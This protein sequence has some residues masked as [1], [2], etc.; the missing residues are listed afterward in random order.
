MTTLGS[1]EDL[2]GV[3][4]TGR[5]GGE[6]PHHGVLVQIVEQIGGAVG[7]RE[8]LHAGPVVQQGMGQVG[9]IV[10]SRVC[11]EGVTYGRIVATTTMGRLA[12]LL[13]PP[14]L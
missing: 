9:E 8:A 10:E 2:G 12:G 13:V 1:V 14:E 6:F 7:R 5:L 3:R 4:G 11:R